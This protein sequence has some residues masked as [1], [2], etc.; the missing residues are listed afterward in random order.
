MC[1]YKQH[2]LKPSQLS[3]SEFQN[4]HT[5]PVH[6]ARYAPIIRAPTRVRSA[7]AKI[8]RRPLNRLHPALA[9]AS[10][11]ARNTHGHNVNTAAE[12]VAPRAAHESWHVWQLHVLQLHS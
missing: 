11:T 12:H 8:A 4:R 10:R 6:C 9:P 2:D 5:A 3:S 7:V 1:T